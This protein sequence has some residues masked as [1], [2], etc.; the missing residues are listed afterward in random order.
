MLRWMKV[1]R[2]RNEYVKGSNGVMSIVDNM[3]ENRLK[4]FGHV[5][6]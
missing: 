1:D 5:M 4:W 2:I 6:R 3:G